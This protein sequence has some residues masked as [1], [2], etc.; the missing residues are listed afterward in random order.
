MLIILWGVLSDHERDF[1]NEIFAEYHIRLYNISLRI[2]RSQD[3]AEDALAQTFLKIMDHI[4][5]IQKI[6]RH[7]TLP[8]CVILLK[9]A[10]V[11][12][13]RKNKKLVP[14][15]FTGKFQELAADTPEDAF[16]ENHDRERLFE[17]VHQLSPEDRYLLELRLGEEMSY[18]E[19]GP[20]L[21]I[22]EAAARKRFQRALKK[23]QKL[24]VKEAV[25]ERE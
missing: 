1:V 12:I 10:S 24:Y 25:H 19:I 11:D 16:F 22:A 14:M 15:D 4:E 8:F 23:L 20:L 18:K 9:N 2:L 13:L 17:L 6:P 3:D 21:N 7:E 5:Q